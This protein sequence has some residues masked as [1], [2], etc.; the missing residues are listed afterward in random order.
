MENLTNVFE[1]IGSLGKIL[2]K[3]KLSK[4]KFREGTIFDSIYIIRGKVVNG[5][6]KVISK[7][8]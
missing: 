2:I 8:C 1:K 7:T 5:I 4:L 6:D 3:R